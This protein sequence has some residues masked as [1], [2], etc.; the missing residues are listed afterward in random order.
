MKRITLYCLFSL[1]LYVTA[2]LAQQNSPWRAVDE[3]IGRQ[4]QDQPDGTR[5]FAMP[6]SDLK[7]TVDGIELKPALALGSWAAFRNMGNHAEVMGDLVP[8]DLEVGPVMQK[9]TDSGFEITALHNHVL[10]ESPDVMYM[11]IHGMGD[12]P[13]LASTLRD[14]LA[15][16]KTPPTAPATANPTPIS[17]SIRSSSTLF[18]DLQAVTM[19]AFISSPFRDLR[20][21]G[22]TA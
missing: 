22:K 17:E 1:C 10:N 3:A 4:G 7:V 5:R 6:R 13:R 14:A 15:L 19:A 12:A 20:L 2:L 8:T 21:F 16:T 9:L 18:C 11:H